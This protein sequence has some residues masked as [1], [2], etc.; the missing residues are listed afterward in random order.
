MLRAASCLKCPCSGAVRIGP[1]TAP[2]RAV[3]HGAVAARAGRRGTSPDPCTAEF[4]TLL[5]E[6]L[7]AGQV[8]HPAELIRQLIAPA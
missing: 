7:G 2:L 5:S 3:E 8:D 1:T 6:V 4:W